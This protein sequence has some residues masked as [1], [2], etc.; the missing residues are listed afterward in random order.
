MKKMWN[1]F[2]AM[3]RTMLLSIVGVFTVLVLM[4]FQLDSLTPGLSQGE[5][6]TY[7][8]ASS[9][10]NIVDAPVNAPYKIAVFVS[11]QVFDSAFG[12][13]LVGALVGAATILLFYVGAI[14]LY[15]SLVAL[16]TTALF[17]TSTY[18]L[19]MTR[20]A[21]STVMLLSLLGVMAAGYFIRFGKRKDIAWIIA[22]IVLGLSLYVPGLVL[23]ILPIAIWQFPQVRK[24]FESLQPPAIIASSVLFGLLLVPLLVSLVR[25]PS[26][27]QAYLGLPSSFAPV[28]EMARYAGTALLSLFII[29]PNDPSMWLGRQPILDVFA[30]TMFLYGLLSLLQKYKLDRFWIVIGIFAITIL[31]IGVTTN[32]YALLILL[33]FVYIVIGFGIQK[34]IDQWMSVFPRNP[35]ARYTGAALLAVVIVSAINFQIHRY[36]VAWP[37]ADATKQALMY[38]I[39]SEVQN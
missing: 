25:D 16:A 24:T 29:S 5:I 11:T 17:A 7:E 33:P 9:V 6:M 15:G 30:T 3:S 32:R 38:E 20:S 26:L 19:V 13:R 2:L 31:W 37:N 18:L 39:P 4:L 23:F 10:S 8:S 1:V 36:F 27:W 35:I 14:R 12:L 34:L 28:N 21:T 22:A